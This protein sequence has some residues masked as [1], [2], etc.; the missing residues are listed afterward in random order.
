MG[1]WSSKH[2]YQQAFISATARLLVPRLLVYL[3]ITKTSYAPD[4]TP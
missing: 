1:A 2:I 4:P 3:N